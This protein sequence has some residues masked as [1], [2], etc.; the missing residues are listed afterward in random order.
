MPPENPVSAVPFLDEQNIRD[1]ILTPEEFERMLNAAPEYLKPILL[2]AYHTGMRRGEI[3]NLT[4][5]RVD[6]KSGFIRLKE[7]DTKTGEARSIPLGRE[8]V[9]VLQRLPKAIHPEGK[10][11]PNVFTRHGQPIKSIR[12]CSHG[13]VGMRISQISSFM[14]FGIRPQRT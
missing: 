11:L 8:L 6:L 4:W 7:S 5:D 3:L 14:T 10:P 9:E 1:R 12:Q 2:C 13:Y